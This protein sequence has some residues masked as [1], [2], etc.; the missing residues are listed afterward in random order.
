MGL[1]F[2]GGIADAYRGFNQGRD[3]EL[4]RQQRE[5]DRAWQMEQR[6]LQR[7]QQQRGL[8]EQSEA[9]DLKA[10]IKAIPTERE[11][12]LNPDRAT[13]LPQFDDDGNPSAAQLPVTRRVQRLNDELARDHARILKESG[14][15][16]ESLKYEGLAD[17]IGWQRATKL[18]EQLDTAAAGKTPREIVEQAAQIFNNDPFSGSVENIRHGAD[19]SVSFEAVNRSTGQ[20]IPKTFANAQQVLDDLRAFYSP[21]TYAKLRESRIAAANE[22]MKPYSL[23]PG[24]QRR[25]GEKIVAENSTGFIQTGINEDG[26]PRL[27]S[28]GGRAD[29]FGQRQW[30]LASKIDK[31]VVSL[32]SLAGDKEVEDGNLRA[33][34]MQVFN[35]AKSGG[36]MAPN[37][38]AEHA[39]TT[40]VRLKNAAADRVERAL[41]ADPKSTMTI[42]QAVREILKEAGGFRPAQDSPPAGTPDGRDA[43]SD[44]IDPKIQRERDIEAGLIMVNEQGSLAAAQKHAVELRSVIGRARGE[45]K[46]MLQG[47]LDRLELGIKAA[48]KAEPSQPPAPAQAPRASGLFQAYTRAPTE[49]ETRAA[50]DTMKPLIEAPYEPAAVRSPQSMGDDFQ[51]PGARAALRQRVMQSQGGGAPLSR[52][53]TLR[54]RQIGLLS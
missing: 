42:Q 3:A 23:K 51:S 5:Q 35:A 39:T 12:I 6:D 18:F 15:L 1:E 17:S 22:A 10:R 7:N 2:L 4:A 30:D 21:D 25:Q 53:E 11:E 38:A 29:H 33:A 49:Q 47:E 50:A 40:I 41:A 13:Q 37:E 14:N 27:V 24:E 32:P 48:I 28:T 16:A 54:A 34:Y 44:R 45:T 31:S 9:D 26:T 19:G 43:S 36:S 46:S 8:Q 20:R 52:V